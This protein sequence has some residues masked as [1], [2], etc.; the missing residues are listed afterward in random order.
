MSKTEDIEG[1]LAAYIDGELDAAQR[2]EIEK[3]LAS[4][5]KHRALI[6][7]LMAQK[8]FLKA[9][10]RQAAPADLAEAFTAQLERAVLLGDVD[11]TPARQPLRIG[12]FQQ[13]RAIAA[14]LVLT[15][16]LAGLI[17]Y[18]LPRPTGGESV[19]ADLRVAPMTSAPE[20]VSEPVARV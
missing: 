8:D 17:Y 14:V 4:H 7:E 13:F 11:S 1:R 18:L 10:P 19:F 6:E 16:G 20:P 15:I 3:H 2:A 12:F 9:L 5:P